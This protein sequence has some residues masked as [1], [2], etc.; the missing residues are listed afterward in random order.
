ML[1][2]ILALTFISCSFIAL[3]A[4]EPKPTESLPLNFTINP[5]EPASST[6]ARALTMV[7]VVLDN[8]HQKA[9]D[10]AQLKALFRNLHSAGKFDRETFNEEWHHIKG[11]VEAKRQTA[12]IGL[13][14]TIQEKVRAEIE[15]NSSKAKAA[16]QLEYGYYEALRVRETAVAQLEY[17]EKVL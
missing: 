6:T 10:L 17:L 16:L 2:K 5:D 9:G 12:L 11:L 14:A 7:V 8:Y 4:S 1:K 3:Q 13:K 15:N